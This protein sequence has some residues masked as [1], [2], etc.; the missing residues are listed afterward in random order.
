M[1]KYPV[2]RRITRQE[3]DDQLHQKQHLDIEPA[4]QLSVIRMNSTYLELVDK[5]FGW[6]GFIT[7]FMGIVFLIITVFLM[8][9]LF[10]PRP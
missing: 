2:D 1:G 7:T 6:K 8:I 9:S 5:Y 3:C 4:Y 10:C